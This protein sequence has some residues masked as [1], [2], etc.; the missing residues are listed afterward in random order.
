MGYDPGAVRRRRSQRQVDGLGLFGDASWPEATPTVVEQ[1]ALALPGG[2]IRG[3]YVLWR[4]TGEGATVYLAFCR[5]ALED[6]AAGRRLAGKALAERVRM[7][8]RRELNNSFVS[9]MVRDAETDH[10]ELKGRFEKRAR[11]AA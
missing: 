11:S 10:P 6:L 2:T 7:E 9:L 5:C 4:A 8:L 1:E 3:D